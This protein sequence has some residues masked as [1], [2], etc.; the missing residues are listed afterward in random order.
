MAR[1]DIQNQWQWHK[2]A[3]QAR[4]N[5]RAL[6]KQ[7]QISTRQLR[8]YTEQIFGM[9]TQ[10]WLNAARLE[11][12]ADLLRETRSPK[13]VAFELGFKQLAHFS[14]EF[15]THYG[16]SPREFLDRSDSQYRRSIA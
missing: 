5:A 1:F 3:R 10:R 6:S 4:Y 13:R 2:L 12:A 7:L 8:R 14:R 11:T 16:L 9:S 15:K